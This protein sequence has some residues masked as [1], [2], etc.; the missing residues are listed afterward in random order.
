MPVDCGRGARS[1]VPTVEPGSGAGSGVGVAV[2]VGV[3]LGVGVGVGVAVGVGVGVGAGAGAATTVMS[4]AC[5]AV[6]PLALLTVN[7]TCLTPVVEYVWV[8][9]LPSRV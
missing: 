6:R 2:G 5:V 1:A 7:T 9:F 3:G 8:I 4:R